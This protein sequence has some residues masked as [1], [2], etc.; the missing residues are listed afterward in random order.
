[1]DPHF[2]WQ[3][4]SANNSKILFDKYG[5][6]LTGD[7]A[8]IASA[9][10]SLSSNGSYHIHTTI[11]SQMD[12]P[13]R[14]EALSDKWQNYL[15]IIYSLAALTSF[16]LNVITVIVLSRYRRS[17]LREYLINLSLSDLLMS[18]FSIRKYNNGLRW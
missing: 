18:L 17:E 7:G 10:D 1:M 12:S 2:S 8:S 3:R 11:F 4:P 13:Y 6:P 5:N 15:V 9:I 14:L 16:V